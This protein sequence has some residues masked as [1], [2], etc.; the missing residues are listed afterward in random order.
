MV[1][2]VSPAFELLAW[3]FQDANETLYWFSKCNRELALS[4]E[5]GNESQPEAAF[6]TLNL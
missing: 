5:P 2:V 1:V 3:V 6:I 4:G